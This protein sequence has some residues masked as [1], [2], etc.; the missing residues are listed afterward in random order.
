[1]VQHDRWPAT[2]TQCFD[3][4]G[5]V[6]QVPDHRFRILVRASLIVVVSECFVTDSR[7]VDYCANALVD[8]PKCSAGHP[9]ASFGRRT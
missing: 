5:G 4:F 8:E 2:L 7:K 3:G 9:G 6:P 1:M